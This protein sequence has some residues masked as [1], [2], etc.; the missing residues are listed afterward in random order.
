MKLAAFSVAPC[1]LDANAMTC[2]CLE[3]QGSCKG[4]KSLSRTST[5]CHTGGSAKTKRKEVHIQFKKR[6]SLT[7]LK[8]YI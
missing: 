3:F 4:E 8:E 6:F 5:L 2:T 1:I 7:M